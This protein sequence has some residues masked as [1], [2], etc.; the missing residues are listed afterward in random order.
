MNKEIFPPTGHNLIAG[1]VF[2]IFGFTGS[3]RFY[4][5]KKWT[6]LLWFLSFGMMGIGWFV[7]L[8]LMPGMHQDAE[9]KYIN[10]RYNYNI[11]WLLVTFLGAFG[12]HRFYLGRIWTGLLWL[13]TGGLLTFGWLYDLW[14][15]NDM[16]SE[17]NKEL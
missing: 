16:V 17:Q 10:G 9:I 11:A 12:V 7:D 3:H 13:C 1:Y 2:W 4:F 5:G 15:L 14:Y 6:G 8:F